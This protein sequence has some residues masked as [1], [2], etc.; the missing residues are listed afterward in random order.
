MKNLAIL[1]YSPSV[2]QL[3]SSLYIFPCSCWQSFQLE[4]HLIIHRHKHEMTLKFSSIKADIPFTGGCRAINIQ[5]IFYDNFSS[6]SYF[7]LIFLLGFCCCFFLLHQVLN[8]RRGWMFVWVNP[9]WDQSLMR[10][11]YDNVLL[12]S[13]KS[14]NLHTGFLPSGGLLYETER[15]VLRHAL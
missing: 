9:F 13:M 14:D 2:T 4:E 6:S 7:F 1:F 11:K 5:L 10:N 12:Y 8:I 15:L 3:R